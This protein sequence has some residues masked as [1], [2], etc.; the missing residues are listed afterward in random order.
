MIRESNQASGVRKVDYV[1]Y[2]LR[3]SSILLAGKGVT[4]KEYRFFYHVSSSLVKSI[5][6]ITRQ[7]N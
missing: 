6:L 3:K 1:R 4:G 5:C 7:V 2:Y